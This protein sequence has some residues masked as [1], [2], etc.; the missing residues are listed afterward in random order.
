ML[1][2]Q[3]KEWVAEGYAWLREK[4]AGP[5]PRSRWITWDKEFFSK[6]FRKGLASP[7]EVINEL[8][9]LLGSDPSCLQLS[10]LQNV[11]HSMEMPFRVSGPPPLSSYVTSCLPGEQAQGRLYLNERL[12]RWPLPLIKYCLLPLI[13][14]RLLSS[15]VDIPDRDEARYQW[16][17]LSGI[18]FGF[19]PLLARRR[20]EVIIERDGKWRVTTRDRAPLP[21]SVF[22]YA[23]VTHAKALVIPRKEL[24]RDLPTEVAFDVKNLLD[25]PKSPPLSASVF[26]KHAPN[27]KSKLRDAVQRIRRAQFDAVIDLLATAQMDMPDPQLASATRNTLG[28]AYCCSGEFA[29]ACSSFKEAIVA[30]PDNCYAHDNLGFALAMLGELD[31][32]ERSLERARACGKNDPGYSHRNRAVLL[33]KRGDLGGA[34]SAFQDAFDRQERQVDFL[35]ALFARF[36]RCTGDATMAST[37]EDLAAQNGPGWS[38]SWIADHFPLP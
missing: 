30:N 28:Y 34:L 35:P 12:A 15:G 22:A 17:E 27:P 32:A 19:G 14:L 11:V 5:F 9:H 4:Y 25:P 3:R 10:S 2:E 21:H 26:M 37:Y 36:L 31:E 20:N 38:P 13:D 6:S 7:Q 8:C 29:L 18:F 24:L 33:W 1:T 16:L 23:L